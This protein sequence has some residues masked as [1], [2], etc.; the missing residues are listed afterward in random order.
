MLVNGVLDAATVGPARI[1]IPLNELN[2]QWQMQIVAP[3]GGGLRWVDIAGATGTTFAPT[4]FHVGNPLRVQA[5]FID[6]LGV[7]ETVVS[8]PTAVLVT[9]PAVNHAP[10][11]V[12]QVAEPGL[13][14]T[15]AQA[16]QPMTL[17]LP[18]VTTF[19]DDHDGGRQPDLHGDAG[20]W[21]DR[22]TV[23]LTF[24][25]TP[26]GAGGVTGGVI[27]GTPPAGFTGTIDIRVK[28]TDAGGLTVTDVFTINVLP[29]V[30]QRRSLRPMAAAPRRWCRLREQH[31]GHHGDGDG[32][33]CGDVLTFS[34]IGGADAALFTIDPTTG[35]LSFVTRAGFRGTDGC[36]RQQHL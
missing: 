12:T 21:S 7:K 35:A 10:T 25:T 36:G 3:G 33:E 14:D 16:D 29:Q 11:V 1:D 4:D 26:D 27:T 31:R 19:T 22:S 30:N 15:S 8:A 9:N 28:A 13:F 23:G 24:A 2:F 32:S 20:G 34:I 17:F 5:S 18:L 6:G